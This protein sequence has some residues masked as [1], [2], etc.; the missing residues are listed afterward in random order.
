MSTEVL[1][2]IISTAGVMLA[3]T[4]GLFAFLMWKGNIILD[5]RKHQHTEDMDASGEWHRLYEEMC[6]R[7][8]SQEQAN[9]KLDDEI[10]KLKQ[11][12]S[13]LSIELDGYKRYDYYVAQL[14]AYT[15]LLTQTLEPLVSTDAY[16]NIS[17]RRP[18]RSFTVEHLHE[19]IDD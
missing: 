17:A 4:G 8:H 10:R 12:V 18:Q 6:K 19:T 7:A 14:E 9:D 11:Q 13:R 3:G 1:V 16:E 15:T 5:N 2:A